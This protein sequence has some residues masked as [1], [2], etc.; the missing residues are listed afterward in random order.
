MA[1]LLR[2]IFPVLQ[3]PVDANGA[4]DIDSLKKEVAFCIEAGA[5]GMVF[6]VLGSEFQ[7]LTEE[8]RGSL[9]EVIVNEAAGRIP[10]VAGVAGTSRQVAEVCAQ[11]AAATKADAVIALPPY[12]A[13]ATPK[14]IKD[15]YRAIA[16]IV[17]RPVF[18]QHTAGGLTTELM[19]QLFAEEEHILYLKEEA[20]PSAH[21]ISAVID[22]VGDGCLG[23]FG[24]AHGRWMLSE[25]ERGATGFMPAV[26]GVDVHVQIWDAYQRGD[27]AEARAIF[28]KLLPQIN[29]LNILGL[30]VCKEILVR[31]GVF[32][33]AAMRTP[34]V[35][36]FDAADGR[37]VDAILADLKPY[38]TV[39][40][41]R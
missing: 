31:R 40:S 32:T 12:I 24:G 2:G 41:L 23:V 25:L 33:S 14:Q 5:H 9:I 10:V 36:P 38:F 19:R 7:Y 16:H 8:E 30:H 11:R 20:P 35:H 3:T 4:I 1:P 6:P 27:K 34:G 26:E 22:R 17:Q 13:S 28:N 15:Y 29:L 21:Q 37:E 39:G 18:I